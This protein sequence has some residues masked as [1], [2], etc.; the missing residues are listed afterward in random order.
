MANSFVFGRKS[1]AR[2]LNLEPRYV[3]VCR[4]ALTYSKV[5][6]S[7]IETIRSLEKQKENVVNGVSWTLESKHLA[8]ENGLSEAWDIYPWVDGKTSHEIEH[9][10][11]VAKAMFRAAIELGEPLEWGGFWRQMDCPHWELG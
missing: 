3:R 8:N 11:E 2:L 10:N 9:Y 4:L 7:I 6:F 5:D 1:E